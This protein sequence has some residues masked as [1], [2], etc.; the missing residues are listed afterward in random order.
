MKKK[1]KRP[2]DETTCLCKF[3]NVEGKHLRDKYDHDWWSR[4][5]NLKES[6]IIQMIRGIQ[7][8][9]E[10]SELKRNTWM[11]PV[12]PCRSQDVPVDVFQCRGNFHAVAKVQI[13]SLWEEV[14]IKDL[15]MDIV[16]S[17]IP[18]GVCRM[19]EDKEGAVC[20]ERGSNERKIC[21]NLFCVLIF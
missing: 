6:L 13:R 20:T 9:L 21:L 10:T 1:K 3:M 4:K 7:S 14:W 5:K 2:E 18:W 11:S 16:S 15:E 19:R 8:S 17:K 12:Y